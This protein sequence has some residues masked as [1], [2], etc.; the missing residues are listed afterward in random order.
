MSWA[1][2]EVDPGLSHAGT[3]SSPSAAGQAMAAISQPAAAQRHDGAI[4]PIRDQRP[5]G[6]PI[7][8]SIPSIWGLGGTMGSPAGPV[9]ASR[10]LRPR[11][12]VRIQR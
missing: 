12:L 9:A 10:R 6:I 7:E 2:G 4:A 5:L 8:R 11:L 3:G 1:S